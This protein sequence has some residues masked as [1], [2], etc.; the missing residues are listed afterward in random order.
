MLLATV[1]LAIAAVIYFRLPTPVPP[2]PSS[3]MTAPAACPP[4][5]DDAD[6]FFGSSEGA[7]HEPDTDSRR[8]VA[9]FL[10]SMG[11]QTLSCGAMTGEIYRVT[12]LQHGGR[13][14]V[15]VVT[16]SSGGTTLSWTQVEG[17]T[18]RQSARLVSQG[19]KTLDDASWTSLVSAVSASRFWSLPS[20]ESTATWAGPSTALSVEGHRNGV[21]HV[22]RRAVPRAASL[23]G[24]AILTIELSGLPSAPIE[25]APAED[26]QHHRD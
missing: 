23:E 19:T 12:S 24:L 4:T 13:P 8:F 26:F 17:P 11:Q 10:R 3:A 6:Y 22:V 7:E 2:E 9:S 18:W 20:N 16:R 21:Y 14:T 25:S 5:Q 15:V 1:A